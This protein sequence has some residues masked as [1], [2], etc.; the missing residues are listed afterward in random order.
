MTG[1]PTDLPDDLAVPHV[2]VE[3]APADPAPPGA[4][5]PAVAMPDGLRAEMEAAGVNPDA[6]A[7]QAADPH[8]IPTDQEA[9]FVEAAR[10]EN[11]M[12][13][14]SCKHPVRPD[15]P[16]V[17]RE[18][19][20]WFRPRDQG[21]QN[22]VIDRRETGALLCGSCSLRLLH[23]LAP[24][25]ES[26]VAPGGFCA[27]LYADLW[28]PLR[29]GDTFQITYPVQG[30]LRRWWHRRTGWSTEWTVEHVHVP[31]TDALPRFAADRGGIIYGR[32]PDPKPHV[33]ST[34]WQ[35]LRRRWGWKVAAAR[36]RVA[37]WIAPDLRDEDDWFDR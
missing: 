25:Q 21:G 14:Q 24:A 6:V 27:P 36:R 13:C 2:E 37:Y 3:G 12:R 33:P 26:L 23:G 28:R 9:A 8:N 29:R 17:L 19:T 4:G 31:V 5:A 35:K 15:D 10:R 34:S 1:W 7:R 18:V 30:R 20:G 32:A 11:G 22:H 16:N